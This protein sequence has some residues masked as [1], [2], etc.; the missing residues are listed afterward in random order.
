MPQASR[1]QG[2]AYANWQALPQRV[3]RATLLYMYIDK[4]I[5][6]DDKPLETFI[7]LTTAPVGYTVA[8]AAKIIGVSK[9]SIDQA[10]RKDALT[11]TRIYIQTP[12]GLKL[13]SI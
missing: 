12:K 8:R 11:A 13:L 6:G 3:P 10:I 4:T 5:S 1:G 2:R 7:D 9:Q